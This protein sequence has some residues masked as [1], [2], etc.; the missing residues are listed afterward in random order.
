MRVAFVSLYPDQLSSDGATRRARRVAERLA[1][2][3]HEVVFLCAQWWGG[4]LDE[5]EH[6]GV[7][8]VAVTEE[9]AVRSFASKL[10]FALRRAS[11]DV[12]HATNSPPAQVVAAK[13]AARVLR[14]PVVVDWWARR[15]DDSTR[16]LR[17]ATKG[18][19]RVL[20]PSRLVKT[21]VREY[22]AAADD[23]TLVPESI[24]F[25]LVREAGVDN[26]ADLVYARDLDEHANV[27]SFLLA[28]AELRGRDWRAA[29][30]GDGPERDA[31]EETAAELRIDDRVSFLGDLDPEEFVP[32]LKGAHVFAQTATVEPFARGLLWALACGCVGIVEYQARSS[33]HELVENLD[34]GARV[35]SPQELAD[36][37]VAAAAHDP[38]TVN[39]A[40]VGYDHEPILTAYENV[41]ESEIDAY[42]FF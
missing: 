2:R 5:F 20:A 14:I 36:E 7:E 26:R 34:R 24:D 13:T 6:N 40:F 8:Y 1:A 4:P 19:D 17:R 39:E 42:G 25:D 12:V 21:D 10:P 41:Y 32:I 27:E 38:S 31:A 28:L 9:P 18:A 29:V 3:G 37:V 22:G 11:P 16:M 33:G 30:I 23:V 35:T 15:A